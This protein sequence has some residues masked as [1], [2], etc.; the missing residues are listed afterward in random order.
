MILEQFWL[1][2]AQMP[3]SSNSHWQRSMSYAGI[4]VMTA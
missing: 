4:W 2:D 3:N 1:T